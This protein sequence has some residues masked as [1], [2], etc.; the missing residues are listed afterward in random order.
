[1]QCDMKR[2]YILKKLNK[3]KKL[4]KSLEIEHALKT[5]RVLNDNNFFQFFK[6]Y[7]IS[8]NMSSYLIE[9]FLPRFRI[10]TLQMM[11]VV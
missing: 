11:S 8:P 3:D 1:M 6:L 9:P 7:K 4:K 10:K 5:Y 2:R